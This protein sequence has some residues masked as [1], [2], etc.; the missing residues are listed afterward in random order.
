MLSPYFAGQLLVFA[1]AVVNE[2]KKRLSRQYP[3]ASK[4]GEYPARRTG[5][6]RRST[7]AW[8]TGP[9]RV[10]TIQQTGQAAVGYLDR[11][12]YGVILETKLRRLSLADTVADVIRTRVKGGRLPAGVVWRH[13]K[14]TLG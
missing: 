2:H 11:A 13:D 14:R 9:G 10:S 5:N 4:V 1:R 12:F 6:L 7:V 3:P 8:P